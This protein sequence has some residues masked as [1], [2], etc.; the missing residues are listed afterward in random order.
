MHLA[1]VKQSASHLP[2]NTQQT[3]GLSIQLPVYKADLL[4]W[5]SI[6]KTTPNQR[7]LPPISNLTTNIHAA[8]T[9]AAHKAVISKVVSEPYITTTTNP[10]KPGQRK[11]KV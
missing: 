1:S 11:K 2:A 4:L 3:S 5:N 6:S 7:A 8:N 9:L 10:V